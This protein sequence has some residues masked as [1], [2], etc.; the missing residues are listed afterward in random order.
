VNGCR[1][2][3]LPIAK[4]PH[5]GLTPIFRPILLVVEHTCI[6]EDLVEELSHANR[7]AGRAGAARFERAEFGVGH[8][9]HVVRGVKVDTVPA[10]VVRQ[11]GF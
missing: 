4:T 11:R 2:H 8:V 3:G 5:E 1:E 9:C 10:P 7:M 6:P